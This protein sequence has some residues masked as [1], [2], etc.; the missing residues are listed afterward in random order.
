MR[1]WIVKIEANVLQ[2]P[3]VLY[4]MKLIHRYD[5]LINEFLKTYKYF[6]TFKKTCFSFMFL[7]NMKKTSLEDLDERFDDTLKISCGFSGYL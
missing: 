4:H 7:F 1:Y 2:N 3:R 6:K 5:F